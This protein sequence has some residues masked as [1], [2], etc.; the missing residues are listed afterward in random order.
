MSA[1]FVVR[2]RVTLW[3]DKMFVLTYLWRRTDGRFVLLNKKGVPEGTPRVAANFA[4]LIRDIH[5][6]VP[7][8]KDVTVL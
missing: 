5:Q 8:L 1:R 6:D 7:D 3:T 2:I 4:A